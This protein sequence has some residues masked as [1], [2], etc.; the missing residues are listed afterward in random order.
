[1]AG[2]LNPESVRQ[3]S[4]KLSNL[5]KIAEA[6]PFGDLTPS[7]SPLDCIQDA[8][9]GNRMPRTGTWENNDGTQ[10][11]RGESIWRPN[12]D[13][14]PSRSNPDSITWKEMLDKYGIDGIPYQDGYP[15][16]SEVSR[17]TV[18]IDDFS[19]ERYGAGGNFD[20]ADEK[21]AE[22][23]GCTKEEVRQW[24]QDNGYTWHDHQDCKTMQKVPSDLHDNVPHTGGIS[25]YKSQQANEA[26]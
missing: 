11:E 18:E 9:Y 22:Q 1:M 8:Y 10:G 5:G 6:T 14:I 20:Q 16:F 2:F 19:D 21:L 13:D 17:G 12:L 3:M 26:A 24:R 25:V 4:D 23:R 7:N 15:D